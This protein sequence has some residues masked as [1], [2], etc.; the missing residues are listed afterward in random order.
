MNSI[1]S[2]SPDHQNNSCRSDEKDDG[3]IVSD[4]VLFEKKSH[5][6]ISEIESKL[7]ELVRC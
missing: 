6:Q 2:L 5:Y 1:C 7:K 4:T 3:M